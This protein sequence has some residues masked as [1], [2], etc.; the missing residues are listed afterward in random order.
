V[1]LWFEERGEG[2]P[3]VFLHP[4]LA[5][6]RL[7]EP[8]WN[9]Y[10]PPY[11]L[12]RCDLPGFGRTA[13]EPGIFR[14]AELVA[15]VLDSVGI[16]GA[17]FVGNS[18]GGRIAL[19]LAVARPALVGSLVLVGASMPGLPASDD[20]RA[21]GAAERAALEARDI[22]AVVDANLRMWVDGPL[23]S[24]DEV[25]PAVR[26]Q[27]EEMC[28]ASVE[29]WLPLADSFDFEPLVPDIEERVATIEQPALV[30]VGTGDADYIVRSGDLLADALP[31]AAL[32]TMPGAGH[33]PSL[34]QPAAFDAL[35]LPFLAASA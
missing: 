33:V 23:R 9:A 35:V 20:V 15:A 11:R 12:V 8:Q 4:A 17:A 10:A 3:V 2:P 25:D 27:V 1:E 22:D 30:V 29:L 28:R 24:P 19:E 14:A 7:W 21:F 18:F 32:A 26:A 34:E 31:H 16:S 6:S 13:P 5:D